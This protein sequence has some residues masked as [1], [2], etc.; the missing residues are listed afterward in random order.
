MFFI[1]IQGIPGFVGVVGSLGM[2]GELVRI[3]PPP[4]SRPYQVLCSHLFRSSLATCKGIQD[5]LGF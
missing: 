2:S 4:P 5:S 3:S 1:N